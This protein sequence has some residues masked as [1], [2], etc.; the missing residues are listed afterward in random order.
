MKKIKDEKTIDSF[1]FKPDVRKQPFTPLDDISDDLLDDATKSAREVFYNFLNDDQ[2]SFKLISYLESL[3]KIDCGFTY[4][5]SLD[6]KNNMTVF[7]WMTSV[8]QY[9]FERYHTVIF[10]NA[11]KRRTNI[12]LWPYLSIVIVNDLGESQPV[13]E[14]IMMAEANESYVFLLT[15]PFK[16]YPKV[17]PLYVKVVFGDEFFN[18]VLIETSGLTLAK[19][20]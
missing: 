17:H 12:H 9:H 18:N 5:I 14:S 1:D 15:S 13:F 6:E 19:N 20:L 4:N 3:S 10:L 8:M 2:C 11:M 16:M 7:T